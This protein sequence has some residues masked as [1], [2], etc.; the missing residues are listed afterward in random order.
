MI[1]EKEAVVSIGEDARIEVQKGSKLVIKSGATINVE[2]GGAIIVKCGGILEVETDVDINHKG[3]EELYQYPCNELQGPAILNAQSAT[4]YLPFTVPKK[5]LSWSVFPDGLVSYTHSEN[6]ITIEP[7]SD[8][9]AGNLLIKAHV[10]PP[11]ADLWST[12]IVWVGD[13]QE[14]Q[15]FISLSA[16]L[17]FFQVNQIKQHMGWATQ[18]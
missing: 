9:I 6:S 4:Y 18:N 8:D 14:L 11:Y 7:L 2:E 17:L 16:D 5:Y 3:T 10:A 12:K 15:D 1:I 13:D